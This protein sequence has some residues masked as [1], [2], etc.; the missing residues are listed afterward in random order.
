MRINSLKTKVEYCLQNYPETRDNDI[1]LF[2]KLIKSYPCYNKFLY[3]SSGYSNDDSTIRLKDLYELP[4]QED[5]ARIRRKFNQH[6]KYKTENE[7]VIRLRQ[8]AEKE[9]YNKMMNDNPSRG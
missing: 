8:E 7:E 5:V 1:T 6:G 9:W 4:K 2:I 3:P